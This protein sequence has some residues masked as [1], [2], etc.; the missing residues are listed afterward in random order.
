M[1]SQQDIK[2]KLLEMIRNERSI[3]EI[4]ELV[5]SWKDKEVHETVQKCIDLMKDIMQENFHYRLMCGEIRDPEGK[6]DV[7]KEFVRYQE[8]EPERKKFSEY[9]E[10]R[11]ESLQSQGGK[12][13]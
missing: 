2:E 11:S 4:M 9:L 12:N 1:T 13:E 8:L 5:T 3:H 10:D 7:M 6:I